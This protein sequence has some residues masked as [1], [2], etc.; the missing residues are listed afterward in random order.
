MS[1]VNVSIQRDPE[2]PGRWWLS[3]FTF[4]ERRYTTQGRTVNEA[5]YMAADLAS[6]AGAD[7]ETTLTFDR[8]E[9]A[10][11]GALLRGRLRS[12][13]PSEPSPFQEPSAVAAY[14]RAMSG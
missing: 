14:R 11:I 7:D 1:N 4:R 9:A 13:E 5:R 10:T 6:L 8:G 3:R 2:T 12:R